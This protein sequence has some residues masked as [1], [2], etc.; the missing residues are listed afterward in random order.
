MQE[1][2]LLVVRINLDTFSHGYIQLEEDF[3]ACRI[4]THN[5]SI[6]I[7]H[8][9]ITKGGPYTTRYRHMPSWGGRVDGVG[10]L[11]HQIYS[12]RASLL[13]VYCF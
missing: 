1:N 10:D 2:F 3:Y 13:N 6:C 4:Y 12:G 9:I 5:I 8:I 7:N 11:V